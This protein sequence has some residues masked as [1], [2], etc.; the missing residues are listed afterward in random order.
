MEKKSKS[1]TFGTFK[2]KEDRF[3]RQPRLVRKHFI[4]PYIRVRWHRL[5]SYLKVIKPDKWFSKV[6]INNVRCLVWSQFP[7]AL[8][9]CH[10]FILRSIEHLTVCEKRGS[11]HFKVRDVD[12]LYYNK[13][14]TM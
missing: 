7:R 6:Q 14:S 5:A 2:E 3:R 1:K 11:E 8:N 10:L 9:E 13:M 12:N 4:H